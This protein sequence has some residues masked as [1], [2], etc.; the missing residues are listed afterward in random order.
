MVI[1]LK[2][3]PTSKKKE[4][5]RDYVK[6][7]SSDEQGFHILVF[8]NVRETKYIQ[9]SFCDVINIIE[10]FQMSPISPGYQNIVPLGY[11]PLIVIFSVPLLN[12]CRASVMPI[13]P[14]LRTL[15]T[16]S[17]SVV[18]RHLHVCTCISACMLSVRY[19]IWSIFASVIF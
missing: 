7:L 15:A 9:P 10:A 17:E 4:S 5:P 8:V 13:S 11:G 12:A 6:N 2:D 16:E 1:S 14:V 19:F 18:F 3:L